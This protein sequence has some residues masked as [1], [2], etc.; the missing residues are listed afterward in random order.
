MVPNDSCN[1]LKLFSRNG[2]LEY[3]RSAG[4]NS[5]GPG[6]RQQHLVTV[7]NRGEKCSTKGYHK[8]YGVNQI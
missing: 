6:V 8:L 2:E 7:L 5:T 3:I 1:Q 4:T